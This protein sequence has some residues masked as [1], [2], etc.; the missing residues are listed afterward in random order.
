MFRIPSGDQFSYLGSGA[1]GGNV[2][3]LFEYRKR[4]APHL[5]LSYQW[6]GNS[7]VMDLQKAP[8]LRLPGGLQY[9]AG[10]DFK[11]KGYLTLAGDI[12]GNQFVNTPSFTVANAKL[13]AGTDAPTSPIPIA[14]PLMSTYT[15]VNLS[16][17]AKV[18]LGKGFLLYGNVLK[19]VN[20]VGL[21]SNLIP[22]VGIAFKK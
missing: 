13:P 6:N 8:Y 4:L 5:K 12:L 9:A 19:Q 10:V 2:Y 11:V 1:V 17:G 14:T 3:G 16:G 18:Y 7:Q 20:N 15:T 21:R 22:L